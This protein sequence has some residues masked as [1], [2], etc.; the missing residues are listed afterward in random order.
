MELRLRRAGRPKKRKE[1]GEK[2]ETWKIIRRKEESEQL[3]V[4]KNDVGGVEK[5]EKWTVNQKKTTDF[6]WKMAVSKKSRAAGKSSF[7]FSLSF[8]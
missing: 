8:I 6:V 7:F 3:H 2:A 4:S 5:K 1:R